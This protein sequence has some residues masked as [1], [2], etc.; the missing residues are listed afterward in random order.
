MHEMGVTALDDVR[1]WK[2]IEKFIDALKIS[3]LF[4]AVAMAVESVVRI[5]KEAF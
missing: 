5:L 3:L 4:S 1:H 2:A